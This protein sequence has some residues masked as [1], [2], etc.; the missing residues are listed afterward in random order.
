MRYLQTP[1][2]NTFKQPD[3]LKAWKVLEAEY[4]V[5][6]EMARD[7]LGIPATGFGVERIFNVGR[8]TCHYRRNRLNGETIEMIMLIKYFEYIGIPL[9]LIQSWQS[10][11]VGELLPA[12]PNTGREHSLSVPPD[13]AGDEVSNTCEWEEEFGSNSEVS[14]VSEVSEISDDD[15]LPSMEAML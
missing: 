9:T 14:E 3:P 10:N 2:L 13:E 8:D 11:G 15:D 6:A 7:I 4:P 1:P 12:L 5:L